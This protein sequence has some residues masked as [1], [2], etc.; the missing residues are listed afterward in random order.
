MNVN[1]VDVTRKMMCFWS[2]R[3]LFEP[4]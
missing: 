4:I 2:C 1:T 3:L